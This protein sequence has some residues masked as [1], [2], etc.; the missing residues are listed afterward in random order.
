INNEPLSEAVFAH[1]FFEI[2]DRLEEAARKRNAASDEPTKPV[3]FRYLTLM[4]LH[5]YICEG[6]DVAIM[7]CGIGGEYD[8]TNILVSPSVTA[9]TNLGID[10]TAM[11]GNTIDEIAW[12]KSGVFKSG[13]AAFTVPQPESAIKVLRQRATE[14][15]VDLTIVERHPDL[16]HLRLGLAAD[17]QKTNASLA[18]SVAAAF[19]RSIGVKDV[20]DPKAIA[21][22]A[23]PPKFKQGLEQVSWPG[24]CEIRREPASN[25]AWHVDG[26]HTL[27]SIEVAG[28]WFAE[29]VSASTSH[30]K[31]SQKRKRIL[32]FNQQT[33]DAAALAKAL[34]TT[35]AA[36]LGDEKPFTHVAFSTNV[37]FADAGYKPDLVSVNTNAD[38][39]KLGPILILAPKPRSSRLSKRLYGG[40]ETLPR[41]RKKR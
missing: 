9:I 4:A 7:E 17:F 35:L 30:A 29:Q 24:R 14:K 37:T 31:T 33:R 27:E 12:H 39:P 26:A 11:L 21:R 34:H 6:V 22:S 20:P 28:R 15:E 41:K 32:L 23:L 36:A 40:A 19:L 1:Y 38:E 25:I 3:Y 13:V 5:A 2:W 10:H 8:S 16:D 18:I